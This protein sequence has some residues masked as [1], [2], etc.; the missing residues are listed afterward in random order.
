MQASY[1][2]IVFNR[3]LES[4][5][6]EALQS[7]KIKDV[8]GTVIFRN[9]WKII[10]VILSIP[11]ILIIRI[12]QPLVTIRL[13][14]VCMD[15][16]GAPYHIEWYLCEK[17]AG[18]SDKQNLDIYYFTPPNSNQQWFKMLKRKLLTFPW[19]R[20]ADIT[21]RL[22]K[23]LPGYEKHVIPYTTLYDIWNNKNDVL[24]H[25]LNAR[26]HYQFTFREEAKGQKEL[27]KIVPEGQPFI[28]FHVRDSA[29]LNKVYPNQ[30]WEYHDYRNASI[31]NYLRCVEKL[32][33]RG[34][35]AIRMGSVVKEEL[36]LS[37][38][39]IINYAENGQRTEFMD[40]YLAAKCRFFLGSDTGLSIVPELLRQPIVYTNWC[41][42]SD[43]TTWVR[44]GLVIPKKLYLKQKNRFLKFSEM[45]QL[46]T[47]KGN[48]TQY[49]KKREIEV[50]ENTPEE[51]LDV[52][53]EMD[54]RLKGTWKTT[55]ENEDLQ[56][57]FWALYGPKKVKSPSFRIGTE[58]LRQN[59][60]L[61]ES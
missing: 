49:L 50:I 46:S 48:F 55:E 52:A 8:G 51:I 18:K 44:V 30:D 14:K 11:L 54:E 47:V 22:N 13:G 10:L 12:F 17:D 42:L 29:Y 16:I 60:N 2:N 40:V 32:V 9:I 1:L 25:A 34:Y 39:A 58:F 26:P 23:W 38:P 19:G 35:I 33:Q 28:C 45:L 6:Y 3:V 15:R 21:D 53:I 4:F 61:L 7:K 20:L 24:I 59:L 5:K 31:R 43:L 27:S 57:R 37:N 56:C 36:I 41:K